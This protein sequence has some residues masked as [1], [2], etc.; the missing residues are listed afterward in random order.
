MTLGSRRKG[1]GKERC[2]RREGS[3]KRHS[4]RVKEGSRREETKQES[5][6]QGAEGGDCDKL[7]LCPSPPEHY[8]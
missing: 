6:F 3:K 2:E 8:R 7:F 1:D 4:Q 5:I